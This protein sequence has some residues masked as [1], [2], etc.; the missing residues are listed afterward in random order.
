MWY[1]RYAIAFESRLGKQYVAYIMEQTAG[2]CVLLTGADNPFTTQEDDSVDIFTPMRRQTGYLRINDETG[3]NLLEQI[4][5]QNNTEKMV[6]LMLQQEVNGSYEDAEVA[7]KGFLCAEAF[8]QPWDGSK[9]VLEFPIKSVLAAL[10]DITVSTSFSGSVLRLSR[11]IVEGV[12]ALCAG[13]PFESVTHIGSIV[14]SEW[15]IKTVNH[16]IFFKE[17]KYQS[18]GDVIATQEGVSYYKAIS[19]IMK[20]IGLTARQEGNRLY[21]ARYDGGNYEILVNT[22]P[23]DTFVAIAIEAQSEITQGTAIKL[24]DMLNTLDFRKDKNDVTFTPGGRIARV[25]LDIAKIAGTI[26]GLQLP[27]TTENDSEV[28]DVKIQSKDTRHIFLRTDLANAYVQIH[29]T[30]SGQEV[31]TFNKYRR[32]AVSVDLANPASWVW[33][34][35]LLSGSTFD[36]CIDN[37]PMRKTWF[38]D[39]GRQSGSEAWPQGQYVFVY[40]YEIVT[41]AFPVRWCYREFGSLDPVT[42]NSGLFVMQKVLRYSDTFT[43]GNDECYS[44]STPASQ[45]L[46]GGTYFN[47]NMVCHCFVGYLRHLTGSVDRNPIFSAFPCFNDFEYKYDYRTDRRSVTEDIEY[48][49]AC[50]L[51]AAGQW[52]NGSGWQSE[53]TTFY[54]KFKNEQIVSNKADVGADVEGDGGWFIPIPSDMEGTVTFKIMSWCHTN[55]VT[56]YEKMQG[57]M[58][59]NIYI[60]PYAKII[61]GLSVGVTYK[62]EVTESERDTNTYRRVIMQRGFSED[63]EINLTIGTDNNN[64]DS[65]PSFLKDSDGTTNISTLQYFSNGNVVN[66]R[67]E[68]HLLGRMVS[69]YNQMRRAFKATVSTGIDLLT[70][71]YTYLDRYFFG[72]DK[73]HDWERDEQEVKFIEVN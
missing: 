69:Y 1:R 18:G 6:V 2:P 34:Y 47:I 59:S 40:N 21:F 13:E 24:A 20:T 45:S 63:K 8:T 30:R 73:K 50:A 10:E 25:V 62:K 35:V 27:E 23:W 66:E 56:L 38:N 53:G 65:T 64:K 19:E 37:S 3:G 55:C 15:M 33:N 43:P 9:N 67:P 31:F 46:Q 29:P 68:E 28:S 17:E 36:A 61:E 26:F 12:N 49:I 11:M 14:A 70:T 7:W 57:D 48:E 52:W 71:K 5:P 22:M 58:D 42:L 41:G 4:I 44:L 32:D 72:I 39:I 51:Y 54:I 60:Y 16:S